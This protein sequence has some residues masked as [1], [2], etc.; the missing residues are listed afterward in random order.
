MP[1]M[2]KSTP[3]S[4]S[5]VASS[6]QFN[7]TPVIPTLLLLLL[8]CTAVWVSF[9]T[10]PLQLGYIPLHLMILIY[11]T[12]GVGGAL[13]YANFGTMDVG[14]S[15][16]IDMTSADIKETL[17][18]WL[19]AVLSVCFGAQL[20]LVFCK[21]AR[22]RML[23]PNVNVLAE[24]LLSARV[25][26]LIAI[27]LCLFT[28]V[29]IVLGVGPQNYL[30]SPQY[31]LV[32]NTALRALASV[33]TPAASFLIGYASG[34]SRRRSSNV[35][36]WG[37]LT[38]LVLVT[39]GTASRISGFIPLCAALG[40]LAAR[41]PLFWRATRTMAGACALAVLFIT[42]ALYLRDQPQHGLLPYASALFHLLGPNVSLGL[43]AME[44]FD[45]L[46]CNSLFGFPSSFA[47]IV[48]EPTGIPSNALWTSLTPLPGAMTNWED[49][50]PT[51]RIN[52]FTPY[53]MMGE[54]FSL[55]FAATF[56]FFT[57]I[58]ALMHAMGTAT[59]WVCQ[60]G[61]SLLGIA[62]VGIL[63]LFVVTSTQYYLRTCTRLLYISMA[64]TFAAIWFFASRRQ[65]TPSQR[66]AHPF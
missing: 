37:A 64:L 2:S 56:F 13:Y 61:G 62:V 45:S 3:T 23:D 25:T 7:P 47:T 1:I 33:T 31:L 15:A 27:A 55:G 40:F 50:W 5:S 43:S 11:F 66:T 39:A 6:P 20:S 32:E 21:I 53:S 51:L 63:V 24:R 36:L 18:Y 9:R 54:L 8:T 60:R 4:D 38:L 17:R 58:G 52:I 65:S 12:I 34:T 57:L 46:V 19:I 42:L 44:A 10:F 48:T 26:P 28:V 30:V 35:L 16:L 41:R 29:L 49:I 14:V 22:V 59:N